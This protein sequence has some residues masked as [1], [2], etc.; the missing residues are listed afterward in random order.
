MRGQ[1]T[2]NIGE[3]GPVEASGHTRSS[4]LVTDG[5][6]LREGEQ[7]T[8]DKI[9]AFLEGV[10]PATTGENS[11]AAALVPWVCDVL[12]SEHSLKGY[13][14]DLGHFA[15]HMSELGVA[16]LEVTA[17]HVKIMT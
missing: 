15:R 14:R 16:A 6:E 4:P 13:G 8:E 10:I 12:V 9:A 1:L 5:T 2:T 3:T 7:S 11:P 17:D